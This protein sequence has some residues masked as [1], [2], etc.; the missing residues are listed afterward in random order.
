MIFMMKK[1]KSIPRLTIIFILAVTIPGGLLSYLSIQNITNLKELTERRVL[2]EEEDLATLVKHNFNA[3]LDTTIFGFENI[4]SA[5]QD[6]DYSLLKYADTIAYLDQPFLINKDG[7]FLWPVFKEDINI[8]AEVFNPVFIGSYTSAERYEFGTGNYPAALSYYQRALSR[9]SGKRDSAKALNAMARLH[10]KTGKLDEAATIYH[11]L[12]TEFGSTRD[13]Y[14]LPYAYY[15][16]PQLIKMSDENNSSLVRKSVGFMLKELED[17]E[18]PLNFSSEI[19]LHEIMEWMDSDHSEIYNDHLD[20]STQVNKI[21]NRIKFLKNFNNTLKDFVSE[22]NKAFRP[23]IAGEYYVIVPPITTEEEMVIIAYETSAEHFAGFLLWTDSLAIHAADIKTPYNYSFLYDIRILDNIDTLRAGDALSGRAQLNTSLT[24]KSVVVRL[25]DKKLLEKDIRRTSWI[26]GIAITLLLGGMLLGVILISRDISREKRLARM[27]SEFVSNVTHELKT[28]LTS[29][30][31]FAESM[32]LGRIKTKSD[33]KEYLGIILKETE[34]LKRLINNILNF[35]KK[36]T[37]KLVYNFIDVNL[38]DL[39]RSALHE[40]DYWIREKQFQL[41]T[42]IEDNIITHADPDALK[43]A[44]LNLL[45]NAIKY[46]HQTKIITVKLYKKGS[47]IYIEVIDKGIGIPKDKLQ[48]IFDKFYRIED[49]DAAENTGTGLG[50]TVVNE[51][52][53]AHNAKIEV[54]SEPGR[55]TK[56]TIILNSES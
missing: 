21:N 42:S 5:I 46:S 15:S 11:R 35:S 19:L 40:Q 20:L 38:S 43:Q 41:H 51:I 4:V 17:G 13:A 31:M 37:G 56:F 32:L 1:I 2:E 36:E 27:R 53:D 49:D 22:D 30:Y 55:G 9:A 10:F 6:N 48:R 45:S 8:E 23:R 26:Y 54:D 52:L 39:L 14:G 24:N 28:P 7:F 16:L 18:L 25:E 33:Q 34:R 3:Y 44:V 29:I 47:S 12:I 50:L